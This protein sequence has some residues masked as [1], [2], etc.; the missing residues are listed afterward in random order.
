MTRDGDRLISSGLAA[1]IT[2]VA[3]AGVLLAAAAAPAV[4]GTTELASLSS[5]GGQGDAESSCPSISA[6][7]RY[8]AF[9][10]QASYL[11]SDDL[12]HCHDVFVRDRRT[13]ETVRVSVAS[14]GMGGDRWS[15]Q[16]AISAEGR[17]VVF[18]STASNLTSAAVGFGEHIYVHD[19][20]T[21]QTAL[22]S[23]SSGGVPGN[24]RSWGP[25]VSGDGRYIAFGSSA[26]NLAAGAAGGYADIYVHDRQSGQTERLGVR[27]EGAPQSAPDIPGSIW[28]EGPAISADGRYVA[29]KAMIRNGRWDILLHDRNTG[30]AVRASAGPNQALANSD[31]SDPSISADGRYVAFTSYA[32][33]LVPGDTNGQPDI[34]VHDRQTRETTR[35]SV[36]SNGG[37]GNG[38]AYMPAISADGRYVA[39]HSAASNLAT[40]D[41]NGEADVFVH[42][43]LTGL[44]T[45]VSVGVD[46]VEGDDWA[47][48]PCISGDGRHVAFS[49]DAA[50]LVPWDE[51]GETDVFVHDREGGPLGEVAAR[52]QPGWAQISCG[53]PFLAHASF[54]HLLGPDMLGLWIWHPGQFQYEPVETLHVGARQYVGQGMWA[55]SAADTT[56]TIAVRD[57]IAVDV[58]VGPGWNLLANPF[59]Q[60]LD[61]Q[62]GLVPEG[63]GSIHLPGYHWNPERFAY[64]QVS[65]ASPG[66]SFWV[67]ANYEGL[68]TFD[69]TGIQA[70]AQCGEVTSLAVAPEIPDDATCIQLVAEAGGS[71]DRS[72]W[73]GATSGSRVLTPKPPV[74]PTAVGAYLDVADGLGYACS[75][76]PRGEGHVW[77]LTVSSP[78]EERVTLRIPDTSML[79][80]TTAVWLTDLASGR[81]VDLRRAPGYDYTAG[82][83]QR[84]FEIELAE[85]D[86]VMQVTAVSAQPAAIGAQISFTLS[87]AGSVTVDVLNIAGRTVKRVVTDR[88]CL[89]GPQGVLW[90]G[91]SDRGT[92]LPDGA[93]LV[94]VTAVGP[95]GEQSQGLATVMLR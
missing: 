80:G 50:N 35:G 29:C 10:S 9:R 36:A 6:D 12:N 48:G 89:A 55:L 43:R 34:F 49:S 57:P 79:P 63:D 62:A 66:W 88:E 82:D 51:N 86:G 92:R 83:G 47:F 30:E 59:A 17:V 24:G 39:F 46:G 87:A 74:A 75:I 54:E 23:I 8:V 71:R 84:R 32:S 20:V 52:L 22:V 4:A 28:Y 93:Y 67:L 91:L 94:R 61:L 16:P 19:L 68:A 21:R 70:P 38:P 37:Q 81:K 26:T 58:S 27:A 73:F 95:S 42:D 65:A 41:T 40:G 60:P 15:D 78:A 31:S 33:N 53:D 25:S 90:H 1:A 85:R 2:V 44:T 5:T 77:T 11:V 56:Q 3:I 69:P 14:N 13:G 45:R 64:D 18:R 76:V 72:V 7:G